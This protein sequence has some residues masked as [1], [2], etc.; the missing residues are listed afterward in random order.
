VTPPTNGL[1]D[2]IFHADL[3]PPVKALIAQ[4]ER[5]RE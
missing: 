3:A 5:L 4:V 1:I 2:Q